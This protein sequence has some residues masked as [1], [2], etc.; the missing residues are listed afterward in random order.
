MS[1]Q[2]DLR[3][4]IRYG[5]ALTGRPSAVTLSNGHVVDALPGMA[6]ADDTLLG[7]GTEITGTE[8]TLRFLTADTDGLVKNGASLTWNGTAYR[9]KHTQLLASGLVTKVFLRETP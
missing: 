7:T 4:M 1:I 6:D 8:R 9:V 2:G 3:H 5:A